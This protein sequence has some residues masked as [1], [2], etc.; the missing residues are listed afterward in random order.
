MS[1]RLAT[2]ACLGALAAPL[3]AAC[4]EAEDAAAPPQR[5]AQAKDP[6]V[7][8]EEIRRATQ[9]IEHVPTIAA[10]RAKPDAEMQTRLDAGE[11]AVVDLTGRIGIRP[12]KLEIASGGTLSRIEWSRWDAGGAEGTGDL[13]ALVCDPDCARGLLEYRN[14]R[15]ELSRPVDCPRGRYFGA[16]AVEAEGTR[17][18]DQPTSFLAAPCG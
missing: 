10:A 5:P 7:R 12:R 13:R 6:D 14:V 1:R 8:A 11:V 15:I 17:P 16:S 4:G 2:L 9:G 3:L 18:A